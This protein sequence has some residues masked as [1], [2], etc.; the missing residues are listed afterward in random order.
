MEV[1]PIG[2]Q[3]KPTVIGNVLFLQI[4]RQA[5]PP[6]MEQI[7]DSVTA[8]AGCL[9]QHNHWST[10][11]GD[12]SVQTSWFYLFFTF[13]L[14]LLAGL[15]SRLAHHVYMA[16]AVSRSLQGPWPF[17]P[18]WWWRGPG[19]IAK[20]WGKMIGCDTQ[21]MTSYDV[22]KINKRGFCWIDFFSIKYKRLAFIYS[23][24][25]I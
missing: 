7:H 10:D 12:W 4:D 21:S 5:H 9:S 19:L 16:P 17:H 18:L 1:C 23:L 8:K 13:L 24:Y 3:L 25:F 2:N 22:I 15:Y 14:P 6:T 20:T 11:D